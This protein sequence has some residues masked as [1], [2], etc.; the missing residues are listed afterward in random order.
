MRVVMV[1]HGF[2]PRVGGIES[3]LG[4]LTPELQRRSL[5]VIVFT[6]RLPG[7]EAFEYVDG[8]PVYRLPAPGPKPVASLIFA[9]AALWKIGKLSPDLIHAHEFI[10]PATV[11]VLSRLLFKIPFL[12]TPHLSGRIGD[13]QKMKGKFLGEF[14]FRVLCKYAAMFH[15]IS[16]EIDEELAETGIPA[17]KRILVKNGVNLISFF[18]LDN[19]A[20]HHLRRQM[21]LDK[22]DQI[23]LF[24]GRLVP[25]KRPDL[26]LE[27]WPEIHSRYPDAALVVIG[28]GPLE[29]QVAS[30]DLR[31]LLYKGSQRNVLPFLQTADI[32][33]I[34]SDSEGL[35]MTL[36]EGMACGLAVIATKV[37]GIPEVISDGVSGRLI[38]VN[39][40]DALRDVVFE[41]LQDETIRETMG[42]NARD[43]IRNGYSIKKVADQLCE[44][45]EDMLDSRCSE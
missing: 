39:D 15:V 9:L 21:G 42:K 19:E 30:A 2:L 38:P 40:P 32:L 18:P 24:S 45:Y 43:V 35:P 14:R 3:L 25:M 5:D 28:E 31:G 6:R 13:V 26:L 7:T 33:L 29:R 16:A 27:I 34:P 4:A 36:L 20:K 12:L 37:G 17:G 10:S 41:V 22:Y 8:V 11:A 23:L 44:V 1:S